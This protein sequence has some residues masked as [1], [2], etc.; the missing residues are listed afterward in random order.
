MSRVSLRSAQGNNNSSRDATVNR[1]FSAIRLPLV[2]LL[3][4]QY[5]IL[6]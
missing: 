6:L 4:I 2:R 3:I 5:F 1:R